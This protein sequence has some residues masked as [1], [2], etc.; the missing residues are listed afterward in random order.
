MSET[1]KFFAAGFRLMN[2][3]R[4]YAY[5]TTDGHCLVRTKVRPIGEL[6]KKLLHRSAL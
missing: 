4:N 2:P 5:M 6:G 1:V 3:D